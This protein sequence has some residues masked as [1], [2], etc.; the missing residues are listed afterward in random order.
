MVHVGPRLLAQ[1]DKPKSLQ[2]PMAVRQY[3]TAQEWSCLLKASVKPGFGTQS[4]Q[5]VILSLL[6]LLFRLKR[7]LRLSSFC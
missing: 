5:S 7:H 4:M 6:T 2:Q 1:E 3:T